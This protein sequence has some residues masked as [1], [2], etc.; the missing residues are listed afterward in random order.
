MSIIDR[1]HFMQILRYLASGFTAAGL[2]IG[3]YQLMLT[4][5]VWYLAAATISTLIGTTTA[6]LLHKYIVFKKKDDTAAHVVR[7]IVQQTCNA[8]IQ[9]FMVYVFVEFM[10]VHPFWA[11]I[12]SIG[13]TVSWNF[14]IYKFLVYV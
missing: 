1:K 14:F 9:V 12:I 5:G 8:I 13:M 3:S 7:Y 10:H 2:E 11:K 4:L 6:F